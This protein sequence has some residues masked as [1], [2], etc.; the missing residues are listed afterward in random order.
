VSKLH[1]KTG[2]RW[3]DSIQ[4]NSKYNPPKRFKLWLAEGLCELKVLEE[5]GD[6]C[7]VNPQ[8]RIYD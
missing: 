4:L 3:D 2:R 6:I 5:E 7:F 8:V 1:G